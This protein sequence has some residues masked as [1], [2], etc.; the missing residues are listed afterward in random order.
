VWFSD[1]VGD[2]VNDIE[3][4]VA[5]RYGKLACVYG[6]VDAGGALRYVGMSRDLGLA[7]RGHLRAFGAEV[8][9]GVRVRTFRFPRR[10]EMS[11]VA[12]EWV[13]RNGD[14]PEGNKEG[15]VAWEESLKRGRE[16]VMTKAERDAFE[17]KK[18][19]LRKAMADPGLVDEA[20]QRERDEGG[21]AEGELR[22][23][24]LRSAVEADDWSGE[25]DA[26]TKGTVAGAAVE[27]DGGVGVLGKTVLADGTVVSPFAK[28]GSSVALGNSGGFKELTASNVD[29]A[30]EEVRPMLQAD[31][32]GISVLDVAPGATA[33]V[34]MT[35]TVQLEGACGVCPSSAATMRLGVERALR[36]SFGDALGEVV[37]VSDPAAGLR[38]EASVG[39]CELLLDEVRPILNGLM[40]SSVQTKS[41]EDGVVRLS[42]NGPPSLKYAIDVLLRE[43]M[44]GVSEIVYEE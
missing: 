36:S 22:R 8:V 5:G 16:G 14:V 37:A 44:V 4:F 35:V 15:C 3:A 17:E 25:I 27:D 2:E 38:R 31:G 30:L 6:V 42:Y 11:R 43:K 34:G 12:G 24:N 9:A 10:R 18:F 39:L 33:D 23:D 26:Q 7:L 13:E 20:E 28:N 29:L 21:E 19:K 41:V 32:G 1:E 40:G